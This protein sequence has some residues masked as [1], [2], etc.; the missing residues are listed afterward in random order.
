MSTENFDKKQISIANSLLHS[1]AADQSIQRQTQ[2]L[3]S[4]IGFGF[5]PF[6]P[7]SRPSL[8]LLISG[9]ATPPSLKD[10]ST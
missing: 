5:S 10:W 7:I 4:T 8:A 9:A 1:G 3:P 2:K 6:E